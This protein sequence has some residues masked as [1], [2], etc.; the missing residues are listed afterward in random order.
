MEIGEKIRNLRLQKGL[1][2]EELAN[3]CELSKGFISQ[4]EN[5]INSVSVTSL[6]DIINALG[7]TPAE[8]FSDKDAE[9]VVFGENEFIEKETDQYIMN[10]LIPNAQ[11]NEMEPLR[12]DL[13][14]HSKMDE[15]IPHDGD[16]FGYVLKGSIDLII[17]KNKSTVKE[18]EAFYYISDKPHNIENNSDE[19]ATFIWISSPPTF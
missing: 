18:G 17:G 8:F 2:Q 19:M 10:W 1:T 13:K 12:V 9:K 15:D 5:D 3:R 6:L 7:V 16:E 4:V 11:K 14:P